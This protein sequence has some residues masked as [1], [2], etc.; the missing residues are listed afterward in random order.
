MTVLYI[1]AAC[2]FR[3]AGMGFWDS[4]IWPCSV[5]KWFYEKH[6]KEKE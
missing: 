1:L 5:A 4:L 3:M 6:M 2:G